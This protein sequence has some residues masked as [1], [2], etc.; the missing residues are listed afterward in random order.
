[1]K[2][3]AKPGQKVVGMYENGM[4]IIGDIYDENGNLI[5]QDFEPKM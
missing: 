3:K 5:E 4:L 2:R 1:M